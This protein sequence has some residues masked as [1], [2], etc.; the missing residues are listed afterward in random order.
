MLQPV[1]LAGASRN[2]S[3]DS[4]LGEP[5]DDVSTELNAEGPRTGAS[6]ET[7]DRRFG[8]R[9]RRRAIYKRTA[10]VLAGVMI[11]VGYSYVGALTGPGADSFQARSVEWARDHRLG[12]LVDRLEQYWYS[13]H[14]AK[15]GGTP[16]LDQTGPQFAVAGITIA[17]APTTSTLVAATAPTTSTLVSTTAPTTSTLVSTTSAVAEAT[18]PTATVAVQEPACILCGTPGATALSAPTDLVTPAATPVANEGHWQ[19]FGSGDGHA[20]GMYVTSIRP[21]AVHTS[22]L[23][24][25][26]WMDPS[27]LRFRHYPGLKVPGAPWDRPPNVE[28]AL[29]SQ[30]VAAFSGGF[31]M[32][33]SS[34]NGGMILAGRELRAM[35]EGGATIVIDVN[36]VPNIGIWGRDFTTADQLDSARQNLDL[37]VDNGA[38]VPDL[39]TDPNKKWGFTG[40]KNNSAVWRSGT[41]ITA[42]GALVWVGGPG[43]TVA[44]LAETLVRAGAIRGMQLEINQE[45]VQLNTY[46]AK[47]DGSARGTRLLP[48]MAHTGDR[49]LTP[50]TRDFVAVFNRG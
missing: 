32:N 6:G 10:L 5:C 19:P 38:P 13:N 9:K 16:N 25:V 46:A 12:G 37:I 35:R 31:R 8:L 47:A 7:T 1:R 28:P 50:D 21:D 14:Q 4:P 15:V 22:V 18:A 42:N 40:P 26:V 44:A 41:G 34:S 3:G 49:W 39:A 36:G 45:W 24:G 11:P 17:T 43:L 27:V 48:G 23:D 20:V 33:D 29:H 2:R 30:L